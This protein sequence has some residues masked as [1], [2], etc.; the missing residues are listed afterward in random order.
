MLLFL[1]ERGH[2]ALFVSSFG[3][4]AGKISRW[5]QNRGRQTSLCSVQ[6][7][8]SDRAAVLGHSPRSLGCAGKVSREWVLSPETGCGTPDTT[9]APGRGSQARGFWWVVLCD[10]FLLTKRKDPGVR[11]TLGAGCRLRA[12]VWKRLYM[13]R[14]RPLRCWTL[15]EGVATHSHRCGTRCQKFLKTEVRDSVALSS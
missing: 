4:Y 15:W 6:S 14:W 12:R 10:L 3:G 11:E 7:V 13:L 9:Y 2:L 8:V 1:P 5:A